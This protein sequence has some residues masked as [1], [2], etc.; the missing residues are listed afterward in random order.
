MFCLDKAYK[1]EPL[2]LKLH[3]Y[4]SLEDSRK[5]YQPVDRQNKSSRKPTSLALS[6]FTYRESLF[7][8]SQHLD[9]GTKA[10]CD[11]NIRFTE[12][13]TLHYGY[14]LPNNSIQAALELI[15]WQKRW[16]LSGRHARSARMVTSRQTGRLPKNA[17]VCHHFCDNAQKSR[18]ERLCWLMN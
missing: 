2:D 10:A 18:T 4:L 8:G 15:D 3:G 16:L 9:L 11:K 5:F 1:A 14:N 12:C 17:I 13:L 6:L 7:T